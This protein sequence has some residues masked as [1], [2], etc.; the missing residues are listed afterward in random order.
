LLPYLGFKIAKVDVIH[1]D[2]AEGKSTYNFS[3]LFKM[4]MD[5]IISNSNKPLRMAV[6]I[7]FGMS[8]LSFILA[9][10]NVFARLVGIIQVEGFTTTVFSIW[11]VGGLMLFVMGILGLYI[12]KIFDQVKGRP[13]YIVMDELNFDKK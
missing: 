10:Y 4:S 3:K 7:G 5:I 9:A 8:L 13:L 11:F 12:G 6:S 2:R 1:A